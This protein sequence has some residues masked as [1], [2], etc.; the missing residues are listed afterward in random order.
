[1]TTYTKLN[2][3]SW[4]VRVKGA[5]A[6]GQ[7]VTVTKK[8]GTTKTEMVSAVLWSGDG[9]S[10]CSIAPSAAPSAAAGVVRSAFKKPATTRRLRPGMECPCCRSE[11]LDGRL[12]CWECGFTGK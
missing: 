9:V 12:H 7:K 3:G 10:L 4:G 5:V 2:N 8:D 6:K 1:M 11:D